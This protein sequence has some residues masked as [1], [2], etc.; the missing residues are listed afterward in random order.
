M[1]ET[2]L[3]IWI[4]DDICDS[5]VEFAENADAGDRLCIRD[6]CNHIANNLETKST[7]L[8]EADIMRRR[9]RGKI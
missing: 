5:I 8:V 7:L 9:L 3:P 1:C 2:F 4:L 6:L